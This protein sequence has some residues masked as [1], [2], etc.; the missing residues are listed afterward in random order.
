MIDT[1]LS[2][3]HIEAELGR[4]GM[5]IVYKA[6]D[7]KLDR[8]VAIKVLPS[9]AL[10]SNDD[11]E[12]FY[13]EAKSAAALN[14]PNIA[15][16][17]QIDEAVPSDAPHGT[18]PSPFIAMEFI[19]GGT[20]EDRI[21]QAPLKL[22]DAVRIAGE[23][24]QALK[25]AHA[26][27]I[28]HRDIKSANVMLSEDGAAKVL[29]FGL[30]KTSQSTMLTR[31]GSTLG[32]IAYMSPE[33]ARGEEVDGR[34]DLWALGIML[35][36]MV[37]GRLPF[38]GDSEQAVTYSILN[39][40]PEPL[41]ALRT[42]V[43]MELEWLVNKLLAKQA[44]ERYQRADEVLVDLRRIDL[45][46][47]SRS[48]AS[49]VRSQSS[50][51]ASQA[52]DSSRDMLKWAGW[53]VAI[54]L[55]LALVWS[56]LSSAAP[57]PQ[58][59]AAKRFTSTVP[60]PAVA[61]AVD[62][63]PDGSMVAFASEGVNILFL[64]TGQIRRYDA[65]GLFV[66]LDFSPDNKQLLVTGQASIDRIDVESGASVTVV[67]TREGG[68]RAVWAGNDR[69]VYEE[70]QEFWTASILT[71]QSRQLVARDSLAG[72]FDYDYPEVLPDGKTLVGSIEYN[73][74]AASDKIG[75][76][77]AETGE[78]IGVLD[79]PGR[80]VQWLETG[81][82]VFVMNGDV[83]A[84]PV[85]LKSAEQLGPLV[86]L[87]GNVG[88]EGLS[89][90]HENTLV[91]VGA[92]IGLLDSDRPVF[93]VVYEVTGASWIN[94]PVSGQS[95]PFPSGIYQS[96]RMSPA[97]TWV[98]VV[99]VTGVEQGTDIV[100]LNVDT[101]VRRVLTTDG[102]SAHPAWNAAGDSLYFVRRL[103]S[104]EIWVMAAS[105]RG[106]AEKVLSTGLP[107]L[108][109]LTISPD[110]RWMTVAGGVPL[111][112]DSITE[113]FLMDWRETL[114]TGV[115]ERE[116]WQFSAQ[117]NARH[118]RFSPD[119]RYLLYEDQGAIYVQLVEDATMAPELVWQNSMNIAEWSPSGDE[120]VGVRTDGGVM[121]LDV[122]TEPNFA[123]L[124]R[125]GETSAT[126]N[127]AAGNIFVYLTEDVVLAGRID[128]TFSSD[129]EADSSRIGLQMWV[130]TDVSGLLE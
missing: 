58:S 56:F 8:T 30:A 55:L 94:R 45:G 79:Y 124:S 82:L 1:T 9:A 84:V 28:V 121:I 59:A 118:M 65:T 24:G 10:A 13:R 3:Y 123:V 32:T 26:K 119:S 25:A 107:T 68:P 76:W 50:M 63:S 22:S 35:Y 100:L 113:F 70:D 87:D 89:V 14:H 101:G 85:D 52:A 74:D 37:A 44:E 18:E 40:D 129:V 41:T 126:P 86:K 2:H 125:S 33:Q 105:G 4:G 51:T 62:I 17:Y 97:G 73:D 54:V 16:V 130:I 12:R 23:V 69:I 112:M 98:A 67:E 34:T 120:I 61:G 103:E 96:A 115:F 77:D 46:S 39:E 91:H 31:M 19:E 117:R 93:P 75:L 99:E 27:D 48:V 20:L 122:T 88:A 116:A 7:T 57:E 66:H 110:G 106:G 38:A 104:D 95:Q 29:D 114:R 102:R 42:G 71:G 64:E 11:R 108:A 36:E 21:K 90:S 72:E 128:N 60:V 49:A 109:D 53:G 83:M 47:G 92:S 5:G 6:R 127:T 43:P 78:S 111:Q 81:H 15:Q 80:R